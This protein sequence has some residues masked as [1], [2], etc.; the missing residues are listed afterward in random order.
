[1]YLSL[2]LHLYSQRP[3]L[4]WRCL[5][6]LTS[7]YLVELCGPTLRGELLDLERHLLHAPLTLYNVFSGISITTVDGFYSVAPCWERLL[8]HCVAPPL[9]DAMCTF[10]Q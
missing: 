9:E 6:R 4:V 10:W 8:V 7:A 3:A 1:M 5:L 2:H